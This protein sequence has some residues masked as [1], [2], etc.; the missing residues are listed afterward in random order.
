M[1]LI[2]GG[3]ETPRRSRL[4]LT[5]D[6]AE[7]FVLAV[8]FSAT[9]GAWV[10]LPFVR[11]GIRHDSKLTSVQRRRAGGHAL[12]LDMRQ[13]DAFKATLRPRQHYSMDVAEGPRGPYFSVGKLVRDF[14]AYYFLPAIKTPHDRPIFR[15]RFR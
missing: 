14:G 2:G 3:H 10:V 13:L 1:Y 4:R 5:R 9:L 11:D 7:V 8:I 6:A 15:Y 12:G